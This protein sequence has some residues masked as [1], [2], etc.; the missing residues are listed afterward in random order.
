MALGLTLLPLA[1]TDPGGGDLSLNPPQPDTVQ[2][3]TLASQSSRSEEAVEVGV[4]PVI[5]C[6]TPNTPLLLMRKTCGFFP[7][8]LHI[9]SPPSPTSQQLS[10][11]LVHS[12]VCVQSPFARTFC[13]QHLT[14]LLN[15]VKVPAVTHVPTCCADIYLLTRYEAR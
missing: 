8:I 10:L 3:G 11:P 14:L 2:T 1:A 9:S 6:H 12:P 15:T 13:F 5:R 4:F 7:L